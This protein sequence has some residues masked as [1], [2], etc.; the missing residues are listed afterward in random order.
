MLTHSY[1]RPHTLV[2]P[3]TCQLP[4][5][6]DLAA[7]RAQAPDITAINQ[8]MQDII[9]VLSDF[10]KNREAGKSRVDYMNQLRDDFANY[11]GCAFCGGGRF[12]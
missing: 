8:R 10:K 1:R 9:F 7:E 4:A 6:D 3:Y 2:S 12:S 5:G 11:Y